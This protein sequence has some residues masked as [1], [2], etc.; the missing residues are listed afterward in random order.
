MPRALPLPAIGF[1]LTLALLLGAGL[2]DYRPSAAGAQG[3]PITVAPIRA[4]WN[5]L[6]NTGPSAAVRTVLGDLAPWVS[7]V[8]TYDPAVARFRSAFLSGPVPGDLTLLS[9][10]VAF[11]AFVPPEPLA[12]DVAFWSR[13]A[14]V[15]AADIRLAPGFNL[16]AWTGSDGVSISTAAAG[17]PLR[18]IYAWDGET[19]RF[20][21]WDPAL[22]PALRDDFDLEYGMGLWLDLDAAIDL[23]W[24]QA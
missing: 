10:G 7:A 16:V 4:G 11:W 1:A 19:Q 3:A 5:L 20:R 14:T 24:P 8:F 13:P 15:H 2:A 9:T 22:P 12:S 23:T 21:A 17:L 6:V 18:R